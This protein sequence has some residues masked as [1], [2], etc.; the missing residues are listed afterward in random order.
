LLDGAYTYTSTEILSNPAPIDSQYLPGQPLLRR[1]KHSATTLLSYLGN[2]WG[3]NVSGSFVGR[4]ADDDFYGFD[5]T[6]AAGYVR[7]DLGGWYAIN[8]RVSAYANVENALD[9]RYNEVVG[10]PALPI[11]FRAGFR[12]RIGG[13]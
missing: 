8:A 4:R 2:R 1:P 5:I 7:A 12:F 13:E 11:N 9:R 10:Y 6:H 3:T